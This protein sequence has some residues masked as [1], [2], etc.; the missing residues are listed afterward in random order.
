MSSV[1]ESAGNGDPVSAPPGAPGHR[2]GPVETRPARRGTARRRWL[3]AI[4]GV[5]GAV[6]VLAAVG[7][8][9]RSTPAR[10]VETV[11]KMWNSTWGDPFGDI[12]ITKRDSLTCRQNIV[13]GPRTAPRA[14]RQ[15][16]TVWIEILEVH[17]GIDL[18]TAYVVARQGS[19][20]AGSDITAPSAERSITGFEMV[21]EHGWWK[22]CDWGDHVMDRDRALIPGWKLW[23]AP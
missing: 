14:D 22:V 16:L 4:S 6:A 19:F 12:D 1:S 11:L 13:S 7:Y 20:P 23:G 3:W 17:I 18:H 2:I 5:V 21:E 8:P 9:V 10:E 15:R